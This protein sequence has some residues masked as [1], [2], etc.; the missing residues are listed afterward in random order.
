MNFGPLEMIKIENFDEFVKSNFYL[1]FWR[2]FSDISGGMWVSEF[3]FIFDSEIG[4][5]YVFP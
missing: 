5:V 2:C 1:V 3:H 4:F